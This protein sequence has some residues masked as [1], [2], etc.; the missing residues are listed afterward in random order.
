MYYLDYPNL[1]DKR[2]GKNGDNIWIHGTNKPLQPNQSNGCVA[3]RNQDIEN[4]SRYIFLGKTPIIIEESIKWTPLKNLQ[5]QAEE[6]ERLAKGWTKAMVDGDWKTYNSLYLQE[7]QEPPAQR[8]TLIQKTSQLKVAKWHFDVM[9]RDLTICRLDNTAVVMFDQIVALKAPDDIH[10]SYVKLYLEKQANGWLI[11]DTVKPAP[12]PGRTKRSRL[13][14]SR[15]D[16]Q[17]NRPREPMFPSITRRKGP[18][19]RL[20]SLSR[21]GLRIGKK[22]GWIN[23]APAM[24]RV[25]VPRVK[26]FKAWVAYKHDLSKRYKNIHVRVENLK[27]SVSGDRGT[28]T[29][30]QYYKAS[31]MKSSGL[32]RL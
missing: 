22:A 29:F 26:T 24:R 28:A 3:L 5:P 23:T 17:A 10:S 1:F 31:N 11:V 18:I 12:A 4:L 2:T 19:G 32:K 27:V 15:P 30:K 9:P 6:F 25:S 13:C 14:R 7:G 20:P 21:N 8:K 16:R